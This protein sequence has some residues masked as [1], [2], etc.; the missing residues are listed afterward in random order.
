M[1]AIRTR[2][3]HATKTR[4]CRI[5]A[6]DSDGNRTVIPAVGFTR[7][8]DDHARAAFALCRT[9]QWGAGIG[10]VSGFLREGQYVFTFLESVTARN[11][12]SIPA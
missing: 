10:L 8:E 1:K 4:P 6:S 5:S 12:H 2:W 7:A 3:L 9:M 11:V